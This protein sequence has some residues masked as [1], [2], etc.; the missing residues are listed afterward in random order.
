[1]EK[2]RIRSLALATLALWLG[3]QTFHVYFP[4]VIDYLTTFFVAEQQALYALA[5]F[6]TVSSIIK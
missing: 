5:T 3:L 1:M 2:N 6:A 4:A